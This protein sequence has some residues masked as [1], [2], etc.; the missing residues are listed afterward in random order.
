VQ[1][2]GRVVS[3]SRCITVKRVTPL[4]EWTAAATEHAR[5]V[6]NERNCDPFSDECNM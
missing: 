1:T 4:L 5:K 2:T 3:S 6:E